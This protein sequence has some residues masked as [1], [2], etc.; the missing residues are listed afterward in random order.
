MMVIDMMKILVICVG[1]NKD[2]YVEAG[3]SDFL[4]K[5]QQFCDIEVKYIKDER[6]HDDIDKVL[7][8]EADRIRKVLPPR[9]KIVVLD[10]KGKVF[11]SPSFAGYIRADKDHGVEGY[12]F[13]IGS[14][15]GLSSGIKA[16]ADLRLSLS[17]LT[18]NHQICRIVLLEQL[19]RGFSI[20]HGSKYHK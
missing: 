17:A 12:V 6:V 18:M 14:A 7:K 20:V 15:H 11:D 10:E 8:K 2:T 9:L 1:K 5:L 3:V 4:K 16:L 13:V 19:Y